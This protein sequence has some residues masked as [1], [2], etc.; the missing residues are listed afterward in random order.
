ML[1]LEVD[2]LFLRNQ[3]CHAS[4]CNT[5]KVASKPNSS[6]YIRN[7]SMTLELKFQDLI[8]FNI[9]RII[10]LSNSILLSP[11]IFNCRLCIQSF[12]TLGQAVSEIHTHRHTVYIV[13]R[14]IFA[15]FSTFAKNGLEGQTKKV[16]D[17]S[18]K[19]V[20]YLTKQKSWD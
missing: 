15:N 1:Y 8:Y 2:A 13:W 11:F 20:S 14:L 17:L 3:L 7:K 16:D 4:S 10:L 6:F 5:W 18:L 9:C 19:K 12:F